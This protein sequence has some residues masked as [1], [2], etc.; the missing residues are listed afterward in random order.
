MDMG[1]NPQIINRVIC[2][3]NEEYTLIYR[4]NSGMLSAVQ[5]FSLAQNVLFVKGRYGEY[6]YEY[7]YESDR[8]VKF[9]RHQAYN[10]TDIHSND[11]LFEY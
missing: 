6:K 1:C 3:Y 9:V 5:L 4:Y 7:Y 11:F 8:L 10:T 2:Q